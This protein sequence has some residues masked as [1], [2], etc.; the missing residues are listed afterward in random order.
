PKMCRLAGE[1]ADGVLFNWLTPEY[2]KR[3]AELVRAGAAAA[4]RPVPK[5]Y[6]YVRV[7]LGPAAERLA[8]EGGRY[9]AIPAYH[10]HFVRMG[11]KPLDT[12]IAAT[13]PDGI[14]EA[15]KAW[16][17]AVDEIVLRAITAKDTVDDH[18]ALVRAAS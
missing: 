13:S 1:V 5:L 12:A 6:A 14:K 2:A 17:G 7:A 11:V 3:S 10:A 16:D 15:L 4:K 18:L 8:D 9:D